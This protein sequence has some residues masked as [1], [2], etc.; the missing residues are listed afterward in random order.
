M[1][2]EVSQILNSAQ[3]NMGDCKNSE[4]NVAKVVSKEYYLCGTGM[5]EC[6]LQLKN[7]SV[8]F[9]RGWHNIN[10]LVDS[11]S[12]ECVHFERIILTYRSR[13]DLRIWRNYPRAL[14]RILLC[15]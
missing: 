10:D 13:D 6:I 4:V 3:K 9:R 12:V 15:L 11:D 2:L 8:Q 7:K 1:G 5:S 14:H